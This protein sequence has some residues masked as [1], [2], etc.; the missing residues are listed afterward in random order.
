MHLIPCHSDSIH[1]IHSIHYSSAMRGDRQLD[2]FTLQPTAA[3]SAK[4][5]VIGA[6][7]PSA[8]LTALAQRLPDRI[9]L[10]TSS[11]SFPG[12]A[13]IVYDQSASAMTLARAGLTS[14]A[15]HPILRAVGID[16]TYYAPITAGDFATY[17]SAVPERFRF[18]VKAHELCT[19]ARF[20][21]SG[22]YEE[23]AGQTNHRFLD[24]SYATEAVVAP[25]V[26]GLGDTAGPLIFQF[27]PQPLATVGG[28]EAFAERLHHFLSALPRGPLYAV[29]LRTP[30]LFTGTYLSALADS[31]AAHCFNV[32]PTMP[33]VDGQYRFA[34]IDRF[35]ALVVR[36]MLHGTL[37]YEEART[38]YAPFNRL[39]DPDPLSRTTIADMCRTANASGR[40]SYII[41]NNKA[42]GSAPLSAFALATEIVA[43]TA[44][45]PL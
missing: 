41:I 9:Y 16:R 15:Q 32:H 34:G 12:W 36:W 26:D 38:Q 42:E 43:A 27:P 4:R 20:S 3:S 8:A 25:I 21:R 6:A 22:R 31:G 1:L 11:W 29:E 5:P 33:S 17:A 40:P 30:E 7:A 23:W 13:G 10:G 39:A 45:L 2:L 28:P 37:G 19:I 44:D 14:Y 24:A 35:P 18:M